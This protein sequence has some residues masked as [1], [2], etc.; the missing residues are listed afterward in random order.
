VSH[1][2]VT[3]HRHEP[4]LAGALQ[5]SHHLKDHGVETCTG[6]FEA[7]RLL[8]RRAFDVVVTDPSTSAAEDLALLS[9]LRE[10]RPGIKTILLAPTLSSADV[11]AALRQHVF[12]CFTRP[13]DYEEVADL[14]RGLARRHRGHLR[15][16]RLDY[17]ARVVPADHG[18]SAHALHDRVPLGHSLV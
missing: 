2:E 16:T 14:A 1:G 10:V 13:I 12:A 9:E 17:P 18:R 8:R 15:A 7:T 11:I 4:A 3:A 6:R 5:A